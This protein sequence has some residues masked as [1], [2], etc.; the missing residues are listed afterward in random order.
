M[1][2]Q[3]AFQ[4]HLGFL[5]SIMVIFCRIPKVYIF[6]LMVLTNPVIYVEQYEK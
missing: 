3:E 2:F 6:G 1:N 5:K 4:S